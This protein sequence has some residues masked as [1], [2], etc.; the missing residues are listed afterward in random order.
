MEESAKISKNRGGARKGAG[1]KSIGVSNKSAT[2][3]VRLR[4]ELKDRLFQAADEVG[5][6]VSEFLSRLIE[7]LP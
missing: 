3:A 7:Q 2:V 1:R 5:I 4:P 6:S